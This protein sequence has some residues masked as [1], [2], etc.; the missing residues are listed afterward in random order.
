MPA[1]PSS[2]PVWLITTLVR[3][4]PS[5]FGTTGAQIPVDGEFPFLHL[6]RKFM[7]LGYHIFDTAFHGNDVQAA[8]PLVYA[9]AL[10]LVLVIL[11][12]NLTAI[13]LRHYFRSRHGVQPR[14]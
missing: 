4:Y 6:D 9:T 10:L 13:F 7:H 5:S 8:L 12:L 11:V 3:N 2:A 1:A 14:P